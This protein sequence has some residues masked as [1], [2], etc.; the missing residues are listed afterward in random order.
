MFFSLIGNPVCNIALSNTNYCNLQQ[1]PKPYSTS[2]VKCGAITS[3]SKQKLSPQSCEC[4]YPYQGTFLFRAPLFRELSNISTFHS[5]EMSLFSFFTKLAL[6]PGAVFLQ[7]TSF[8]DDDYLEMQLALFPPTGLYFKRSEVQ[9]I[10]FSLSHQTYKPPH[11]FGPYYFKAFDYAFPGTI[12]IQ[13]CCMSN[14]I[15]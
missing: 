2:L 14:V 15:P 11:E 10:G 9:R 8:N 7:N 1:K 6:T 13:H 4:V 12:K 3:P 5:L